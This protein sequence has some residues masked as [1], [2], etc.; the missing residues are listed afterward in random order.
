MPPTTSSARP[1]VWP[2]LEAGLKLRSAAPTHAINAAASAANDLLAPQGDGHRTSR[3]VSIAG[4]LLAN[5]MTLQETTQVCRAWNATNTPPLDSDKVTDTCA[6]IARGDNRNHPGRSM[7]RMHLT[8]LS[9]PIT[10]LFD[11]A[12][13]S[14]GAY[15]ASLPP[16]RRWVLQDFLPLG[17]AAAVVSPGGVGKSQFLMQLAYSVATGIPLAG[18]WPIGEAG[19]VLMLCAEDPAEEIHRRVFRIH[20]QVGSALGA[21]AIETLKQRLFVRS[22]VG[23]NMLMT[24]GDDR[25]EVSRTLLTERLA[26]TAKQIAELKL[27]IIDPASRFRGGEENSNEDATRFVEALEFLAKQTGATV[28]IAHHVSKAAMGA[29]G[30]SQAGARGASALTDGLRW[31][32]ALTTVTEWN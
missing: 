11:S 26:I 3:L 16:P 27:I 18:C 2:Q 10:P 8:D 4:R 17:I 29:S 5:G 7:Q 31:Q 28:L 13:A 19:A 22:T 25:G 23:D 20:R 15:L 6:S 1:D 21:L 24:Q 12:D 32:L 14:I 30:A 9:A